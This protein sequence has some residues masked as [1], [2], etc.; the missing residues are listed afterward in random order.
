MFQK[1]AYFLLFSKK[2]DPK[3]FY[4]LIEYLPVDYKI[5]YVCARLIC[6]F[7]VFTEGDTLMSCSNVAKL[8]WKTLICIGCLTG[9]ETS[10][11]GV[12]R[13]MVI[14][15]HQ[16]LLVCFSKL[17][18]LLFPFPWQ[19]P[20]ASFLYLDAFSKQQMLFNPTQWNNYQY[21]ALA[22]LS[23]FCQ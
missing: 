18:S 12:F 23:N 10:S 4:D 1:N 11:R 2:K 13:L 8:R 20:F 21:V 22:A 19:F 9:N 6:C 15:D 7:E 3:Y 16:I 5:A 14:C 17:I